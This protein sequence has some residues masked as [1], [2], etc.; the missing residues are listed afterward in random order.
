[1]IKTLVLIAA[2]VLAASLLGG[3]QTAEGLGGDLKW[4]G[5][6]IKAGVDNLT[7]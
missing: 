7:H 5:E 3:C 6:Q 1:M 2:V 4:T